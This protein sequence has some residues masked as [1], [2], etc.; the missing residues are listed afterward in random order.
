MKFQLKEKWFSLKG[1]WIY[2][3]KGVPRF[4][5]ELCSRKFNGDKYNMHLNFPEQLVNMPTFI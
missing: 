5:V 1:A 3:C 2:E 4:Q